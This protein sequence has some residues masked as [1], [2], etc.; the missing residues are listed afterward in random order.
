VSIEAPATAL[1]T[2][3]L[4]VP[5]LAILVTIG[6]EVVFL[7]LIP[8]YVTV[9]GASHVAGAGVIRDVLQGDAALHFRYL[10]FVPF[11]APNLLPEIA[12]GVAMLAVDPATGEKALQIAYV[13]ALPLAL[14]YAVRSVATGRDWLALIAVPLTFTLAFQFGFYDFSF[15]VPL[16]LVAAGFL[17]RHRAAPTRRHAVAFAVLAMLVYLTHLVPFLELMAFAGAVG[18]GRVA[19][20]WRAAG[21]R[22]A[23]LEIRRLMPLGFALLPT[24]VLAV[25]F[26][27]AS[28][29]A[30][31]AEFLNLPLQVI[32][33]LGLGLG[34]VTTD[35]L[36]IAV[37]VGLAVTLLVLFALACLARVRS[38]GLW[39]RD[40]DALLGYTIVATI[41]A[42]VAPAAVQS[43]GSYIP[44]RLALFPVYGLTLW[45]AAARLPAWAPRIG[46]AWLAAAASIVLLRL[47]TTVLLSDAAV[48]YEAVARCVA[49]RATV[50]QVN[51][52]RLPSGSIGRTDPFLDEA[53]R[54]A[55]ATD[56]YDLGNFEGTFP[57]FLFR[58]RPEND[59]Y[60][61][62]Q[63]RPDGFGV[64]PAIDLR[65]YANRPFGTV[66]YVLVVGAPNATPETLASPS[67]TLLSGQ[68][69]EGYRRIATSATGLVEAW[70]RDDPQLEEAGRDRRANAGPPCVPGAT[71]A[72]P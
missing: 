64:P 32:G 13:A 39:P 11:P 31:P 22:G 52:S 26:L 60:A 40:G 20:E 65:A 4:D 53:G 10:D 30:E 17:W 12:L 16:F 49:A 48:E 34:I 59:P 66:D 23:A 36:E 8:R 54:I 9:D 18:A 57:F 44:E 38:A 27:V 6:V 63:T 68:L 14:L 3:S 72:G 46:L 5:L 35:R 69:T 24:A 33:V 47:P 2:R 71:T 58:N 51:L 1:R 43:G 37:A 41:I 61:W 28:R 15:G 62:L 70:E 29:S 42:C 25:G 56:G 55:S 21:F 19:G 50:L 7:A 67:W 45:L